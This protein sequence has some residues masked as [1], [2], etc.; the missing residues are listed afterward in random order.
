M[1]RASECPQVASLYATS[2]SP[3]TIAFYTGAPEWLTS[4]APMSPDILSTMEG[5]EVARKLVAMGIPYFLGV[6]GLMLWLRTG[7]YAA[8]SRRGHLVTGAARA[9]KAPT[10]GLQGLG[11][12]KLGWEQLNPEPR[13]GFFGCPGGQN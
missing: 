13:P 3:L 8:R 5:E 12:T 1:G 11:P 4:T 7:D 6:R 10:A 2:E 9:T